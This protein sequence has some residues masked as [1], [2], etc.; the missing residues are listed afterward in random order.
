MNMVWHNATGIKF[1][2]PVLVRDEDALENQ[3]SFGRAQ[4]AVI[5]R[6]ECDRVF[7]PRPLEVWKT[8]LGVKRVRRRFRRG[9]HTR[10]RVLIAVPS[11]QFPF[12][13]KVRDRG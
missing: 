2:L 13:E 11:P 10:P 8:A 7:S 1:I 12:R 3:V 9:E 4:L 5:A 6:G